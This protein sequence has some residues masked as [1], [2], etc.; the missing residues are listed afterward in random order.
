M[1]DK[2]KLREIK[3]L[4]DAMYNE[5]FHLTTDASR[6]H[7]AMEKY[8]QFII[9]EYHKE[10]PVSKDLKEVSNEYV[11]NIRKG[12]PRVMDATDRYI[13][14]AFKAG[15]QW[16]KE[17]MVEKACERFKK[18]LSQFYSGLAMINAETEDFKKA[19]EDE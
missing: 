8:H 16:Q 1:T 15:A 12:Y 4:A 3:E 17:R 9:H 7:G 11:L 5:A 19:M 2:E 13:K 14:N 18:Y 10:E 6:L